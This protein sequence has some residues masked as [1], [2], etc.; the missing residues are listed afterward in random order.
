MGLASLLP[1][2]AKDRSEIKFS[3]SA[4]DLLLGRPEYNPGSPVQISRCVCLFGA[5]TLWLLIAASLPIRLNGLRV[6][7]S[8]LSALG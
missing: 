6:P 2:Q 1:L 4:A 7:T 3:S 8:T 5:T